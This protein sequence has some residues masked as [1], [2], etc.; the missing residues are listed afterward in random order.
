MTLSV[1][2]SNNYPAFDRRI[3]CQKF[4]FVGQAERMLIGALR[5]TKGCSSLRLLLS[6]SWITAILS[7]QIC[8]LNGHN[9]IGLLARFFIPKRRYCRYSSEFVVY[10]LTV[11]VATEALSEWARP[12][13]SYYRWRLDIYFEVEPCAAAKS[14]IS[15]S[16]EPSLF[17]T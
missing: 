1:L 6:F 4:S 15:L 7:T 13:F 12:D 2:Y 11:F 8:R 17:L 16:F 3:N 10:Q 9:S 5:S 14:E